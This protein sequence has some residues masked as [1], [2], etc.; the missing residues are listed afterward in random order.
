MKGDKKKLIVV[1]A[2]LVVVLG[3]GAFSFLSAPAP[4][5]TA[6]KTSSTKPSTPGEAGAKP[7]TDPQRDALMAMVTGPLPERDPFKRPASTQ[8]ATE[9]TAAA[10]AKPAAARPAVP[11]GRL[12]PPVARTRVEPIDPLPGGDT[13]GSPRGP[14][15]RGFEVTKGAPV[16]NPDEFAFRVQ[17]VVLGEKP[18]AVLQDEEGNQT[19][20]PLG[21]TIGGG[22]VIAIERDG[23]RI[24]HRGKDKVVPLSEGP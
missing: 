13:L 6:T 22:R 12:S 23:V 11:A 2:V 15:A 4:T 5:V 14:S 17:G 10:P 21:G 1:V 7:K 9:P 16:R 18:M 8:T 24:R 20:V 19:L 3:V